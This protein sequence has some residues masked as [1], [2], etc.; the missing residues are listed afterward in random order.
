MDGH[1]HDDQ[2][3]LESLRAAL[4]S[5]TTAERLTGGNRADTLLEMIVRAAARAI[6]C[7][8][9]ALFLVDRQRRV[10]TFEVVIGSTA[11]AVKDM[12]VP[13]GHG[14]AGLVAASGQALA[15]ANAQED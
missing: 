9:G 5:A 13:L 1:A 6:P 4:I 10:L 15:I 7:P 3:F 11:D 12:T 2:A 8:E 14:I